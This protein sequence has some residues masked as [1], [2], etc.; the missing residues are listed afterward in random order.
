LRVAEGDC[1]MVLNGNH[2]M[3]ETIAPESTTT[4]PNGAG[5]GMCTLGFATVSVAGE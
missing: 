1:A 2:L 4:E 3:S 5:C